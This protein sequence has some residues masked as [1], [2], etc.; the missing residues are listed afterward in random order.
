MA[1]PTSFQLPILN[2][3][4]ISEINADDKPAYLK[5][6]REKEIWRTTLNIPFPYT[7]ADADWWISRVQTATKE[8]GVATSLAIRGASGFLIGG[9]GFDQFK[10]GQDHKAELGYWLAK[11]FWGKGVTTSAVHAVCQWGFS[12]L[13]LKRIHA[14]VFEGNMGSQRVLEKNGFQLEGKLRRHYFK[15]EKFCD[16]RIYGLLAE[17]FKP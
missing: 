4:F 8:N 3:F 1:R 11:P 9:I 10:I 13:G 2:G 16:A 15:D 17:E 12:D 5:H 7:E 14:H 6:L